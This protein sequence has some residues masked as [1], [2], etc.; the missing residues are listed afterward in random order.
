MIKRL[1]IILLVIAPAISNAQT[2]REL[3]QRH[4]QLESN[5][6]TTAFK[7]TRVINGQSVEQLGGGH[8]EFR[9][10]E[11]FGSIKDGVNDLFGFDTNTRHIGVEYGITDWLTFGLGRENLEKTFDAFIKLKILHQSKR[12]ETTPFYM[13]YLFTTEAFTTKWNPNWEYENNFPTRLAYTNQLLIARKFSDKFTMQLT[14]TFIY[15]DKL[16]VAEN[17]RALYALG[18]SGKHKLSNRLTLNAEYFLGFRKDNIDQ[19]HRDAFAIG[20]DIETAGNVFQLCISNNNSMQEVGFI[21]GDENKDFFSG[22]I[23][24]GFNFS[25]TISFVK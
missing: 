19:D 21:W 6:E 2:I 10:S 12:D 5:K 7:S 17:N 18:I 22:G 15:R 23:H 8:L 11:R 9:Y 4:K 3:L 16:H 1:I 24:F 25:R 13:S 14:P 20:L